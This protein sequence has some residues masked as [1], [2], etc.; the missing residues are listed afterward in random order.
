MYLRYIQYRFIHYRVVSK[1]ELF[2]MKKSDTDNRKETLEH[3]S[4]ECEKSAID[5][6]SEHWIQRIWFTNYNISRLLRVDH[7]YRVYS[8]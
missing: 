1:Y 3:L 6:T 7:S 5:R 2:K 4:Y 8:K